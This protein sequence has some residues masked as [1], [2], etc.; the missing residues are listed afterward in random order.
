MRAHL[1]QHDRPAERGISLVEVLIALVVLSVGIMAVSSVFPTGTRTQVQTRN[2]GDASYY[3]LQKC[4][5]LKAI[6]WADPALSVG[7]HPAGV[8]CDTLGASKAWTRFYNVD[9][10]PA[11]LTDL[12]RIIVTVNWTYQGTR[13][14]TD[15]TYVRK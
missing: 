9:V 1:S 13:S 3:A 5:D 14:V 6:P 4:E 7:R 15:T 12:K 8:V 11:P 10:L 2:L